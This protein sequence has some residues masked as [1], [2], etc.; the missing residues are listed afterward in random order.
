MFEAITREIGYA[1]THLDWH[2]LLGLAIACTPSGL[3]IWLCGI[4]IAR[5][6]AVSIGGFAGWFIVYAFLSTSTFFVVIGAVVGAAAGFA[7]EAA[8]AASVGCA[9]AAYRV[10]FAAVS[11]CAGTLLVLV[12]VTALVSLKEVKVIDHINAHESLYLGAVLGMILFGTIEQLLL[13]RHTTKVT[14]KPKVS[15]AEIDVEPRDRALWRT[16]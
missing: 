1:V 5:V 10:M 4:A 11:A 14:L 8:L 2:G 6:A 12:G 16:R 9:T 13:C 7:V 15:A 3:I